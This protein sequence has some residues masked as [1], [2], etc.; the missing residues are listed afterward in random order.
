M[1]K[2][3]LSIGG[4]SYAVAC[5]DGEEPRL[6]ALAAMVDAKTSDARR[7]V[8]GVNETR[9]LLFAAL[10]LADELGEARRSG[11]AAPASAPTAA[12][13]NDADDAALEDIAA[14]LE[15]LALSLEQRG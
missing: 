9:Q 10:L 1:A 8:G 4:N 14:R 13:S 3:D 12:A 11:G 15:K 6:L 2:V 7:A 5:R